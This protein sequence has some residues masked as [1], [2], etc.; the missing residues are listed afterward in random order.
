M[1]STP[2]FT[3]FLAGLFPGASADVLALFAGAAEHA[4]LLRADFYTIRDLLELSGY[5]DD[6]PLHVLLLGLVLALDEG[7][8]CIEASEPGLT[9]R[10]AQLAA[11]DVLARL[12]GP[13]AAALD[14]LGYPRL[15]GSDPDESKPVVRRHLAGRSYLYFQK[16][17]RHERVLREHLKQRLD[18]AGQPSRPPAAGSITDLA[19]IRSTLED[20]LDRRPVQIRGQPVQLNR[21]QRLAVALALLRHFT[22]ISGGPG[23]GKTSIVFTL[24]RC[25]TRLGVPGER[26]MLAAPTGRA[27]QRLTDAIRGGLDLLGPNLDPADAA[28][29]SLSAVTLHH[30][31]GYQPALGSFRH[32]VENPL[33][34]DVVIVDET[35]MVGL[36]LMSQLLQATERT[37]RLIL[38]GDKDQLPSVEAGAVMANLMAPATQPGFSPAIHR[39][40]RDLFPDMTMPVSEAGHPLQDAMVILEENYRSEQD[41]QRVAA[42]VNQQDAGVVDR[43]PRLDGPPG[44]TMFGPDRRGCCLLDQTGMTLARWQAILD[45]WLEQHYLVPAPGG[46]SYRSLAESCVLTGSAVITGSQQ[47]LLDR[48]FAILGRARVLTLVRE[49]PWGGAGINRICEQKL[50]PRLDPSGPTDCFLGA[51]ILITRNDHHRGLFNGDVGIVLRTSHGG[52]RAVFQRQ[53]GCIAYPAESLPGHELAFALT[54]HKSQG[55]EYGRVLLVLPGEGGRRLLTK[56]MIYTGITRARELAVVCALPAVLRT[57]ISRRVERESVL[58][59]KTAGAG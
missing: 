28:L 57:A 26:I 47:Q 29:A 22:I 18:L 34:A 48:L 20:V 39:Q 36:V 14:T 1:A 25:L 45:Q 27:A 15:I 46:D 8:L 4:G 56:E 3:G 59:E 54:V 17:Y 23:T 49:G 40:L 19:L 16:Y 52:Y 31:L 11:D 30:L 50:R 33:S 43:L 12:A 42:A 37:T 38:L 6:D 7:S 21:Q 32:H 10:L 24:L 13:A 5:I 58:W 53:G 35:S 44:Q 41:I 55:S 51:P 9:R 2:D